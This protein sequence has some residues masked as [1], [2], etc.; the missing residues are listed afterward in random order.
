MFYGQ[1][2][3]KTYYNVP[4]RLIWKQ[5]EYMCNKFN[6]STVFVYQANDHVAR[7]DYVGAYSAK[8]QNFRS[9]SGVSKNFQF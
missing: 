7:N 3:A 5:F 1:K 8:Y 4:A 6:A 9:A 2:D